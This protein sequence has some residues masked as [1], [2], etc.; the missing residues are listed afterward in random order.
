MHLRNTREPWV[1]LGGSGLV[2]FQTLIIS[3]EIP[4]SLLGRH[5]GDE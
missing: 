3:V 1:N 5:A 2:A 4:E